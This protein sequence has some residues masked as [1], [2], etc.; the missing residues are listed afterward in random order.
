MQSLLITDVVCSY[1]LDGLEIAFVLPDTADSESQAV[2]E[3]TICDRD[4]RAVR[5][6]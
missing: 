1:A 3:C 5:F 4:V 6:C 2:V